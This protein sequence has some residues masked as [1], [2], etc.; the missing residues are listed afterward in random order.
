MHNCRLTDCNFISVGARNVD[1]SVVP[2]SAKI[3]LIHGVWWV[4][5]LTPTPPPTDPTKQE[6][7]A[8]VGTAASHGVA[9]AVKVLCKADAP[10]AAAAAVILCAGM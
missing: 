5:Q 6:A 10:R 4:K 8:G 3:A 7:G 9:D 1:F 2:K